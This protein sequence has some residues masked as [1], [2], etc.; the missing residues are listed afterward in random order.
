MEHLISAHRSGFGP[1]LT[2]VTREEDPVGIDF[3]S[4]VG[5]QGQVARQ[6]SEKESVWI[7]LHGEVLVKWQGQSLRL[8]RNS[9]FEESPSA[10]V[11]PP[12]E[13]FEFT[14]QS[15]RCEWALAAATPLTRVEPAYFPAEATRSEA[16]GKDLVQGACSRQVRTIFDYDN[17]PQSQLVVGEVVNYPGRWSS[18]PPHHHDQAELYHYRFTLP[19]GYGHAEVGESVYK[20][21]SY[22]TTLIPPGRDHAQVS[23]PGYGM[24]YL[25]VVRHLPGN[26][27]RGFKFTE[28]HR[29]ILDSKNQ[30]WEPK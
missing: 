8:I 9:L 29:W 13:T 2:W 23:A 20:I 17:R 3:G 30:G 14:C 25:W 18:Y 16:R 21:Y 10:F 5:V 19:Q 1:G 11:V 6:V 7:L 12:G 4:W 22:D 27:Y 24:Y 15:A 28:S 26:P